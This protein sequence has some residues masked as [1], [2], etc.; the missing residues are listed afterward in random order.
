[1]WC[2][3]SK[4]WDFLRVAT[5]YGPVWVVIAITFVIYFWAGK[6][7]FAKRR[8]LRRFSNAASDAAF[9]VIQNPFLSPFVSVKTTEIRVTSELADLPAKNLSTNS[10]VLNENGRIV[11][12]Q[13]FDPYTV[14]IAS[15]P[16]ADLTS[17]QASSL[18]RSSTS[19][20]FGS[21]RAAKQRRAA[22]E[23]NKAAFSYCKCAFLFFA[24][25]LI[26]WV[27]SSINRVYS[28]VHPDEVSFPLLFISALVLPLQG[29]WNA[30]IYIATSL[31]ACKALFNQILDSWAPTRRSK[32]SSSYPRCPS[33]KGSVESSEGSMRTFSYQSRPVTS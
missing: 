24:S 6:E 20:G 13:S 27:P 16:T 2:W 29:F 5:F 25:L 3:V 21:D 12:G 7:I 11:S 17:L 22:M 19:M 4:E 33:P 26:T 23:A 18:P 31:P 9:P 30:V 15:N 1:M 8:Q 10:F 14:S 28:L 32:P